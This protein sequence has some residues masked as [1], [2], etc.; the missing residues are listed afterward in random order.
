VIADCVGLAGTGTVTSPV[1]ANWIEEPF[2]GTNALGVKATLAGTGV[3]WAGHDNGS[4]ANDELLLTH[5]V[6]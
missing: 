6:W 2:T 4:L 3:V 5:G 1:R